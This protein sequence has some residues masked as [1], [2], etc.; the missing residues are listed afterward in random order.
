VTDLKL[1]SVSKTVKGFQGRALIASLALVGS[2]SVLLLSGCSSAFTGGG[3]LPSTTGQIHVTG[4]KG[5]VHGGN[6]PVVG[7]TV[8]I[9]SVAVATPGGYG[10]AASPVQENGAT[11]TATTGN[12][13]VWTYG[14]YTCNASDELYV[15]AT[16]GDPGI[17]SSNPSLSL[18]AALGTCGDKDNLPFV[19]INE[20]TTV[21]TAYSLAGFMTP[22]ILHIGTSTTNTKGL[23][24]AFATFNNLVNLGTGQAWTTSP[25]YQTAPANTSADVFRGIVP[26]DTINTLAD[27]LATC[28]NAPGTACTTLFGYTGGVSDTASAALYIAHNPGLTT[29]NNTQN[30]ISNLFALLPPQAPF[31]PT[32]ASAP[33]DFTLTMNFTGGGLG[34]VKTNTRSGAA[35]MAID[36]SGDLWIPN[37]DRTS[38]T[39]LSNLGAPLSPTTT[40]NTTSPYAPIALGGWGATSGDLSFPYMAAVD[41]NGNVW[42]SDYNNCL[43]EFSQAGAVVGTFSSVCSAGSGAEAV[44]VDASNHVWVAGSNGSYLSQGDNSGNLQTGF[45]KTGFDQLGLFLGADNNNDTWWIDGGNGNFGSYNEAGTQTAV[46]DGY[47]LSSAGDLAAFGYL[48]GDGGNGN[49]TIWLPQPDPTGNIQPINTGTGNITGVPG[50][51]IPSS[52]TG[53]PTGIAIDGAGLIYFAGQQGTTLPNNITVLKAS[54]AEIS[55]SANGYTGGSALTALG[56]PNQIVVDQS[57]NLWVL[58]TL[59]N[60]PAPSGGQF[61]TT[62]AGHA[63]VTEFVGLGTP[64]NPVYAADATNNTFA[65]KP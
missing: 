39:E 57:G 15:V 40:I 1:S 10:A 37:L 24:N 45:P 33:N 35:Y 38:V 13:G 5:H 29:T 43:V 3:G 14:A 17:G 2:S 7:A 6:Q 63:N 21:A 53:A 42:V 30:N 31:Q 50:A 20:V 54:G 27:I 16:G 36:Q 61:S 12:D 52:F 8:Q 41:Q 22:D 44:S 49:L 58:N 18:M 26:Y 64:A 62:F 25:A 34:G 47:R 28:V 60:N 56:G 51:F 65:A 46:N 23:T 55:P 4:M 11:V 59:N 9:Y 32:L 48:T 19:V